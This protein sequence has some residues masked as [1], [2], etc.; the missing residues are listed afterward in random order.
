MGI[1][2][3]L[4]ESVRHHPGPGD[5]ATRTYDS[6]VA[7]QTSALTLVNYDFGLLFDNLPTLSTTGYD[8]DIFG[9]GKDDD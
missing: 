9:I 4:I 2:Y 8:N 6:V 1:D 7:N 3:Q 5:Y